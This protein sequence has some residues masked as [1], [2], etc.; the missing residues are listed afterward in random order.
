MFDSTVKDVVFVLL[1]LLLVGNGCRQAETGD[2]M[3]KKVAIKTA[4]VLSPPMHFPFLPDKKVRHLNSR[5]Q[6]DYFSLEGGL[7]SSRRM[8]GKHVIVGEI[9]V[10][11]ACLI[12][13]D[14]LSEKP[15]SF[16]FDFKVTDSE[17]GFGLI[18]GD[19]MLYIRGDMLAL[20]T[21]DGE[22]VDMA[23]AET[24]DSRPL[25]ESVYGVWN[26]FGISTGYDPLGRN[27][28][29]LVTSLRLNGQ[30]FQFQSHEGDGKFGICL[31]EKGR[32]H[33]R[34]FRWFRGGK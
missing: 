33:I 2:D 31:G 11:G 16:N 25:R 17:G 32:V 26:T 5:K 7:W 27:G 21:V 4:S 20:K 23:G 10:G 14:R 15:K 13:Q 8:A 29:A 3:E 34:Q 22:R 18:Y 19:R 12:S 9:A 6:L 24:L 1:L 28:D 30:G